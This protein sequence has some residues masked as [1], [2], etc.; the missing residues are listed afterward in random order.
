MTGRHPEAA[1]V[2]G[3]ASSDRERRLRLAIVLNVVIVVGQVV[4][5]IIAGSLGLLSDAGHNLTDVAALILSLV[6]VRVA[7]RRPT[8]QRSFGWHRGTILAAQANATMILLLTVWIVFES[9]R[10]LIDPPQ[11]E[12]AL[13]LVVALVAFAGNAISAVVVHEPARHDAH[14]DLNMRA[15]LLHLAGD[16][17]AS[18][19]VAAA[20]GVMWATGGWVRLDPAVSLLIGV[21]IAWQAWGLLRASNAVLLEG[22]PE[23]VDPDEILATMAAVEGVEAAHD[24]HVWAISS[25]VRA[26]SAHVVVEGHPTLEEAQLVAGRVR[27]ELAGRFRIT[28]ATIEL[29]CE[30]C[31]DL[32]PACDMDLVAPSTPAHDHRH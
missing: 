24:L 28:H 7:R 18:L 31:E 32:G 13:V 29:E 30:T 12:G 1:A 6:A 4:C 22:A 20:G 5:G 19:G 21:S 3:A 17:A 15:A 25:D 9:I 27:R 11:V 14:P 26:L 16:A 2:H 10:R 8:S 23:G